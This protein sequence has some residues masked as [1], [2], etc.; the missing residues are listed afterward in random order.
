M[1]AAPSRQ[2]PTCDAH[3]AALQQ[4]RI[5]ALR[6]S[7]LLPR[8][9]PDYMIFL[10]YRASTGSRSACHVSCIRSHR[11]A[12]VR[13]CACVHVCVYVRARTR[14]CDCVCV[15]VRVRACVRDVYIYTHLTVTVQLQFFT[16]KS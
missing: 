4:A 2:Q 12:C 13:V 16:V 1:N 6:P 5:P 15:Y 9:V 3:N 7:V 10:A 8:C 14:V 11:V